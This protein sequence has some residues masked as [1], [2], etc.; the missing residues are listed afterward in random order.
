M[1]LSIQEVT[2]TVMLARIGLDD[3]QIATLHRTLNES[4]ARI[5]ADFAALDLE[6]VEA[7]IQPIDLVNSTREDEPVAPLG[8]EAALKNAP[9]REGSAFL[10]PRIVA[11]GGGA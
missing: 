11:P 10:V 5:D 8:I 9:A 2:D 6:G 3:E 1:A 4:L 7:T